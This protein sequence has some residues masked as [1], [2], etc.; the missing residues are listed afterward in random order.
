MRTPQYLGLGS[1]MNSKMEQNCSELAGRW[2]SA[3]TVGSLA[4]RNSPCAL[5]QAGLCDPFPNPLSQGLGIVVKTFSAGQLV[6]EGKFLSLST[7][8]SGDLSQGPEKTT[9]TVTSTFPA[10]ACALVLLGTGS[11]TLG[12]WLYLLGPSFPHLNN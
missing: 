12:K 1:A 9:I 6:S 2:H 4:F 5:P 3:F 10:P 11:E 8:G 7:R